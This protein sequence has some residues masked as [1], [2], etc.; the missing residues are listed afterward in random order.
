MLLNIIVVVVD[1]CVTELNVTLQDFPV[2]KPVSVNV[3]EYVVVMGVKVAVIVPGPFIVAVVTA[4]VA[5]LKVI[6]RVLLDH[7]ENE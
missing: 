7:V 3:T 1:V 6:D 2:G 4:E 5:L